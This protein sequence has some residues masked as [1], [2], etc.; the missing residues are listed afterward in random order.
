MMMRSGFDLRSA[1]ITGTQR[2]RRETT[3]APREQHA[4]SQQRHVGA[5]HQGIS[6]TAPIARARLTRAVWYAASAS[7]RTVRA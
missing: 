5:A 3:G 2:K 7:L 4:R 6:C 1:V